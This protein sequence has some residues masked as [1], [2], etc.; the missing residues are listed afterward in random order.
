MVYLR[1]NLETIRKVFEAASE[2]WQ[3]PPPAFT[4]RS[5]GSSRSRTWIR[6]RK[7]NAELARSS[8][9]LLDARH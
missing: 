4:L 3:S 9:A 2:D 5:R 8:S 6:L 7:R 1:R